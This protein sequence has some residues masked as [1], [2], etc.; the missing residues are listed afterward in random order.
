MTDRNPPIT[1]ET[2]NAFLDSAAWWERCRK[3]LNRFAYRAV[4]Q[5]AEIKAAERV[6]SAGRSKSW[7]EREETRK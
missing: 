6:S 4:R 7:A 3:P 1:P 5:L 2:L